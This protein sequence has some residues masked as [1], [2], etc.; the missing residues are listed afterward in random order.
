MKYLLFGN[1]VDVDN[2]SKKG[3]KALEK[4]NF[5]FE[6]MKVDGESD[7]IEALAKVEEYGSYAFISEN[8]YNKL[9]D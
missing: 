6:V 7:F 8:K 5:V 1:R 4:N 2:F 9:N 3:V